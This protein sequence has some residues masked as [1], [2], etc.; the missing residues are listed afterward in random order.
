MEMMPKEIVEIIIEY[1]PERISLN[2]SLRRQY[3]RFTASQKYISDMYQTIRSMT[4]VR[5]QLTME[6]KQLKFMYVSNLNSTNPNFHLQPSV[7]FPKLRHMEELITDLRYKIIRQNIFF[8]KHY[9]EYRRLHHRYHK[10]D[11]RHRHHR[12]DHY[13][14]TISKI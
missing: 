2:Q 5:Q 11:R 9:A 3:F 7:V 10:H 4:R 12:H 1:L 13:S 14:E 6:Y 8:T